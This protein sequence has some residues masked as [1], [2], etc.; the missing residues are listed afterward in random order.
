MRAIRDH[1]GWLVLL[2]SLAL[3]LIGV[4]LV[5]AGAPGSAQWCW[6]A[7]GVIGLISSAATV[8]VG[9]VRRT[10]G[11]DILALLAISGAIWT[12]EYL[13]AALIAVMLGTGTVLDQWAQASARRE[14]SQLAARAPRFAHCIIN[15]QIVDVGVDDVAV[16]DLVHVGSGEIIPVDAR[17]T[18]A[19]T[20]DESALTGESDPRER[21]AGEPVR[22][23]VVNAGPPVQIVAT[24]LASESTY[25][26]V[27]RMVQSAQADSSP[28]VRFA[29]R[30][31]W[32]FVPATLVLSGLVWLFSGEPERVVAVLVVATPCPLLLAVPVAV[33]SG[34]SQ[35]ARRGVVI[36]GGQ[37]LERLAAGRVLLFDKTGT[38][39][40]GRPILAA[41]HTAPG[42]DA[43]DL[44]GAAA[45]L[46]QASP[47]VLASAIVR[48]AQQRGLPL[49]M[50]TDVTEV[51]GHGIQGTVAG[52]SVRIG[53]S[54][55]ILGELHPA[56]ARR[57]RHEADLE[58]CVSILVALD[59]QPAGTLLFT[60][61]LRPDANR[62]LRGLRAAG[63]TRMVLVTG[64][65]PDLAEAVGRLAGVDEVR[66][67]QTPADKVDVVTAERAY[68][69]VIMVGDGINDAPALA[70]AD[71]GVAM[72]GRGATAS[73]EAAGIVLT[74]DRI[75][76]LGD[77]IAIARRARRI[78]GQ[79]AW[80]GMG[81]S[82]AAM[83]AAALGFLPAA[84]GALLQEVIDIAAIGNALRVQIFH[85]PAL[86]R[87][88]ADRVSL[89]ARI[90]AEHEA[91]R[92]IVDD[93]RATA[94]N[95]EEPDANNPLA[96]VRELLIRLEGE[97]LPHEQHEEQ[98]LLPAMAQ[99]LGGLDPIGALSRTHAEIA[100]QVH[101]LR[102]IVDTADLDPVDAV[103]DARRTLYVLYGVLRLH[104]A[105]EDEGLFSLIG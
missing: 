95:L 22:S 11:V 58:G 2:P 12:D 64:D 68:G 100:H 86:T 52:Q 28:Y 94:D 5:G 72:A 104:N 38:L 89:L 78:A 6:L 88:P 14:L 53:K 21:R 19:G 98:E 69:P 34:V 91:L 77:A 10:A 73:S 44:L 35:A 76:R 24:A 43:T 82:A 70:A 46:D 61:A 13:A 42:V 75:D 102:R 7:A 25:A 105:Q 36:K 96:P 18:A 49:V 55:W 29:D 3:L 97:L 84:V 9:L 63:L 56:W 92:P 103:T 101:R 83:V 26:D 32:W 90:A 39:T 59:G 20:F 93:L 4:V 99:T 79:S 62:M 41:I 51:H 40:M 54:T 66:S 45:S 60:D 74:V 17:L 87:M 37:V 65:R 48:A 15:G 57:A 71:V 1:S 31:A 80:L 81:L 85:P 30:L 8:T 67:E 50:P 33:I 16:G 47:H 23:G 27:V